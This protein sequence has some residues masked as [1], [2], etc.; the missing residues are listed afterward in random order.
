MPN[1]D[2]MVVAMNPG[3]CHLIELLQLASADLAYFTF[4]YLDLGIVA[5]YHYH[6]CQAPA[7]KT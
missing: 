2:P 4:R 5:E 7:M 6:P 3:A 1:A